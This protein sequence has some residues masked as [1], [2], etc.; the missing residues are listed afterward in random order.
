V[1]LSDTPLKMKVLYQGRNWHSSDSSLF[2]ARSDKLSP[3]LGIVTSYYDCKVLNMTQTN[4]PTN[5]QTNQSTSQPT[6]RPTKQPTNQPEIPV[7]K[8]N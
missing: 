5:Q 4:Q 1:G 2:K 8:Q 3:S 7:R 6:D